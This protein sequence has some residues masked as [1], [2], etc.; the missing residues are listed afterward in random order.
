MGTELPT[1]EGRNAGRASAVPGL[2]LLFDNRVLSS[3]NVY[4]P[5]H[6]ELTK[7]AREGIRVSN[8]IPAQEGKL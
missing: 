1:G 7:I 6:I 8:L 4:L 3:T 2:D 5:D